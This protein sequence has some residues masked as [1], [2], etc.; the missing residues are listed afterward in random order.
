MLS[1]NVKRKVKTMLHKQALVEL[2]LEVFD[3]DGNKLKFR[4]GETE[5]YIHDMTWHKDGSF[6]IHGD[7]YTNVAYDNIRL[8]ENGNNLA[9]CKLHEKSNPYYRDWLGKD[10]TFVWTDEYENE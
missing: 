2:R 10:L 7:L 4:D 9:K 8:W 1:K 3:N 6:T 5:W